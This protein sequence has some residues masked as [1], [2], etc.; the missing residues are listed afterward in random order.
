VSVQPING[1]SYR[2]RVDLVVGGG[3]YYE[4]TRGLKFTPTVADWLK[5]NMQALYTVT[6]FYHPSVTSPVA[7]FELER[8]A[9][10]FFMFW[11]STDA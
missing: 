3:A 10:L 2:F 9:V 4:G 8:D 7:L 1:I 5:A 6:L 11:G